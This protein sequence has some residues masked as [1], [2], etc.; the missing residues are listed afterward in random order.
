MLSFLKEVYGRRQVI[1]SSTVVKARVAM[2]SFG[3][4]TLC[5]L[6]APNCGRNHYLNWGYK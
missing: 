4:H 6:W 1:N 3:V 2:K 5:G